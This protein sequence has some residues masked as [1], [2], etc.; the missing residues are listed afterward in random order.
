M[1]NKLIS[2]MKSHFGEESLI[3]YSRHCDY[4]QINPI[5]TA[6]IQIYYEYLMSD[7][8][9]KNKKALNS[10]AC[11]LYYLAEQNEEYKKIFTSLIIEKLDYN[12]DPINDDHM[13]LL[14]NIIEFVQKYL[15][16]E[17]DEIEFLLLYLDKFR[18]LTKDKTNFLLFQYYRGYLFFRLG[19]IQ[20][21]NTEYLQ[22]I[23]SYTE[24]IIEKNS[25]NKYSLFIQLQN[26]LF[27]MKMIKYTQ[28]DDIRQTRIF[29]KDLYEQTK[30]ENQ[31]LAIKIG[32]ELYDIYLKENSYKD[33]IEI[34]MNMRTILKKKL[35][36]G[37][38]MNNAIDFYLAIVCRLGYVGILTN[39]KS[40]IE[41]SIKKLKK[42]IAMFDRYTE[43]N[44]EKILVFKNAYSYLLTIIQVD[45][46]EKVDEDKQKKI[47]ANFKSL[48]LPDLNKAEEKK[49][50]GKFIV[51][52]SNFYDTV[53]NL[54]IINNMDY[55][56]STFWKKK[57]DNPLM[58]TVKNNNPLQQNCVVTFVLSMHHKVKNYCQS[59][60][61]DENDNKRIEYKNN[62]V[63]LAQRLLYYIKTYG[64]DEILFRTHFIKG[65]VV[66]ILSA[67]GH[68]LIY[69][70][71]FN[72]LKGLI[73]TIDS[74]EKMYGI[75]ENTPSYELIYKIKGDY[76]LFSTFKDIKA[77]IMQYEKG[78]KLM[79][80][81]HPKKPIILFNIA[82][83]HFVN[84]DWRNALEFLDRCV[85]EFNNISQ[86]NIAADF[87][88]R[89]EVI[90]NK[91]L[92][93]KKM[94]NILNANK[95]NK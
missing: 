57:I 86:K 62:I 55:E 46:K 39:N 22:F 29:L 16:S 45:N 52:K 13:I 6:D 37:D 20:K 50:G 81:F 24:E 12:K 31:Y 68:V 72:K 33:C 42:S 77:A 10:I 85:H 51:N 48:F 94:I 3:M 91:I 75:N 19:E 1:Y 40:S 65:A 69:N 2:K 7:Q 17:Q 53:V 60:C 76:W 35:L 83:C 89:P 73:Q 92:L 58:E 64:I 44:K 26:N 8:V 11:C 5:K 14:Y 28:G 90:N 4:Y 93:A 18:S 15:K 66:D 82:Y 49:F 67:Y 63:E 47:V 70:K 71:E 80:S 27:N 88:Y 78:Y 38:R 79:Q 34:L 23:S 54:E 21:A 41:N 59:Y 56:V 9:P 87:Y 32:F 36:T 84:N 74:M 43:Q 95:K 61:Q 30:K 25:E